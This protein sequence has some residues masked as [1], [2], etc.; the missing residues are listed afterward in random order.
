[1]TRGNEDGVE[2]YRRCGA[3]AYENTWYGGAV[4]FNF[5]MMKM[6]V[7]MMIIMICCNDLWGPI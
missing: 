1:M 4:G 3:R 6:V 7:G 5:Q 2:R